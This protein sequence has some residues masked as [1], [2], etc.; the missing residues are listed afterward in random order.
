MLP[1]EICLILGFAGMPGLPDLIGKTW[2]R[3]A[4]CR[5]YHGQHFP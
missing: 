2:A 5:H 1:T 3:A 4:E